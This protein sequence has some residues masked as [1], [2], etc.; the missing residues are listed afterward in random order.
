MA[1]QPE[2]IQQSLLDLRNILDEIAKHGKHSGAFGDKT[3]WIFGAQV[4]PT[5]L[6]SHLL[7]LLL[8][9]IE[10]G[11]ADV[12]PQELQRWANVKVNSPSWQKVMHGR[13]TRYDPSMGPIEDMKDMLT[14]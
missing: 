3:E 9:M 12:V 1:F 10:V 11:N 13:P 7:P 6:D 4:G 14:L 5:L 2:R 8:R